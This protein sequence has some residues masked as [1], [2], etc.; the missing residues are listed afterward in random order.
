MPALSYVDIRRS[1]LKNTTSQR[2]RKMK[3]HELI[4]LLNDIPD[5]AEIVVQ[6][7]QD[8]VLGDYRYN[9]NLQIAKDVAHKTPMGSL[10]Y[11]VSN[12]VTKED[13]PVIVWVL[14]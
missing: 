14:E 7:Y 1:S 4:K 5:D 6:G 10:L 12:Y 2:S 11:S 3:K 8:T 9:P 13:K